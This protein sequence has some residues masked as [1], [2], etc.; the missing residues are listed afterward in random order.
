MKRQMTIYVMIIKMEI[1][2]KEKSMLYEKTEEEKVLES[3]LS[4]E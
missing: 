1:Y 2:G 4:N 3:F